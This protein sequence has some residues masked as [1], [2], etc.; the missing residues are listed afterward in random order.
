MQG[1]FTKQMIAVDSRALTITLQIQE[2]IEDIM[3]ILTQMKSHGVQCSS[4]HQKKAS[5]EDVFLHL[6][7]Q[8]GVLYA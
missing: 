1:L 7:E 8:K 2:E 4:F 6:V 5:L 3:Y